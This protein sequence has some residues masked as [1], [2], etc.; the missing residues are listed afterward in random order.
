MS[1]SHQAPRPQRSSGKNGEWAPRC[2]QGVRRAEGD[3]ILSYLGTDTTARD[4]LREFGLHTRSEKY[5]DERL[6]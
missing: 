3:I 4:I 6:L 5:R 2:Q 1:A